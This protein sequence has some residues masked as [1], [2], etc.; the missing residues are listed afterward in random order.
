MQV[1]PSYPSSKRVLPLAAPVEPQPTTPGW[2][3]KIF[4]YNIVQA[5]STLVLALEEFPSSFFNFLENTLW[6]FSVSH[7]VLWESKER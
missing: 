5:C 6:D 1:V 3:A 7:E 4:P 2:F